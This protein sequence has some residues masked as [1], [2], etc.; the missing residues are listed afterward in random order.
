MLLSNGIYYHLD[1]YKNRDDIQ[2]LKFTLDND[3]DI[4]IYK[5]SNYPKLNPKDINQKYTFTVDINKQLNN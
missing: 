5:N 2:G 1:K 3:T 4:F